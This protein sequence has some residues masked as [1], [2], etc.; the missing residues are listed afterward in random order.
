MAVAVVL[1]VPVAVLVAVAG[2]LTD[3]VDEEP[4]ESP[5]EA[6]ELVAAELTEP[7]SRALAWVDLSAAPT[8]KTLRA[9]SPTSPTAEGRE[10]TSNVSAHPLELGGDV[11]LQALADRGHVHHPEQP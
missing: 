3:G 2:G 4:A 5:S 6:A 8:R 7:V 11:T 10:E 1:A 9:T